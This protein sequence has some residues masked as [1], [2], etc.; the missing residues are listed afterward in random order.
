MK[1][2]AMLLALTGALG[3]TSA[4]QANLIP[5]LGGQAYY[6]TVLKSPG[7]RTPVWRPAIPLGCPASTQ[8]AA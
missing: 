1:Q 4:V 3:M 7:W 8:T 5:R 6:D 2:T